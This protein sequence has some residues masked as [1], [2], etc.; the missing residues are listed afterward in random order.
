VEL[1]VPVAEAAASARH[2]AA[3]SLRGRRLL[4]VD[5]NAAARRI[6]R[7]LVEAE[8]GFLEEAES[9]R[10]GIEMIQERAGTG[11]AYQVVV[12]DSL[13]PEMDGFG[14]AEAVNG[15]SEDRRPN[16]LMLTS[17]ATSD[18]TERARSLGVRGLLEKPASR[19]RLMQAIGL[20]LA[21]ATARGPERRLVTARTL[22][23]LPRNGRVLLADDSKVNHRV[24]VA[25]L[26]KRG[27]TV[28]VVDNGVEAVK[29]ALAR[30][31][32]VVLMDIE[33]PEMD[34][35]EATAA[36]RER[37]S[38]DELP[39]VA[40]TAHVVPELVQRC[41]EAGMSDFVSKPF[42]ADALYRV[43]ER[44]RPH[45]AQRR[46]DERARESA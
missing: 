28:D 1:T 16:L 2:V 5:D 27:Y 24:A 35:L 41:R 22:D 36:I 46:S 3:A 33:M 18:E 26:E 12:L 39:I 21:P 37:R 17:A 9:G 43:L 31:Y 6:V 20:L 7:E 14:V 15:M 8:G 10:A 13:M 34:G 23:N 45:P 32:D 42:K 11:R 30:T 29:A 38:A 44:L 40:L 19:R 4:V 25:M